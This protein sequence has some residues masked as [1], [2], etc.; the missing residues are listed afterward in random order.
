MTPQMKVVATN[1]FKEG[2][3]MTVIKP[4]KHT[5]PT[6]IASTIGRDFTKPELKAPHFP[7]HS[8]REVKHGSL[9][10]WLG[11]LAKK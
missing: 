9:R 7:D 10:D 2:A 1:E 4:H 8:D 6:V 11:K 5:C 3:E